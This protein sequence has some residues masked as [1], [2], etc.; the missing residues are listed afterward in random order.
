MKKF[1]SV[2]LAAIMLAA[3]FTFS[4]SASWSEAGLHRRDRRLRSLP[5]RTGH[6]LRYRADRCPGNIRRPSRDHYV[7]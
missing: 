7:G 6:G 3:M 2:M 5:L 1:L 4:V